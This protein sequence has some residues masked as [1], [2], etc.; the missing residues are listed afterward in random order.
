[1]F[2]DRTERENAPKPL[3]SRLVGLRQSGDGS[4]TE[5]PVEH[6][7]LLRGADGFAPS[8]VPLATLARGM[9]ADALGFA[10]GEI[11]ERMAQRHRQ[12]RFNDLPSR[13]ESVNRGF[14]FQA[15]ELAAARSRLSQLAREGDQVASAELAKIKERQRRL[16]VSRNRR[17][18]ELQAE[19]ECIRVGEVEILVHRPGGAGSGR[20]GG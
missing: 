18:A 9:V 2:D 10:R 16:T 13:V 15:A 5:L 20:G 12:E 19:P 7:L 17:L 8:R 3:E 4:V 14:D 6:L 11:G 1:M